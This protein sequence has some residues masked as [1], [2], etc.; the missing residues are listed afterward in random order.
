MSVPV[1]YGIW[2]ACLIVVVMVWL[3]VRIEVHQL[4]K[5]LHRTS[6]AIDQARVLQQQLTLE[7]DAR[8]RVVEAERHAVELGL[9]DQV[10]TVEA[11]RE[12]P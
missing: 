1:R 8:R 7:L 9:G 2:L 6:A 3:Q 5:D 4:R 11:P 12:A 10:T